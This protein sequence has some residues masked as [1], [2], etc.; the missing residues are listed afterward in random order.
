MVDQM[1]DRI[2]YAT[3][4]GLRAVSLCSF[5]LISGGKVMFDQ[6]SDRI[7]YATIFGL[8]AVSLCSFILLGHFA[9]FNMSSRAR[10]AV[11]P[12]YTSVRLPYASFN[13]RPRARTLLY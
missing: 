3:I 2:A 4:F 8:R 6:M 12:Y 1:S 7:A 5:I 10:L 9:Y 13:I 11:L